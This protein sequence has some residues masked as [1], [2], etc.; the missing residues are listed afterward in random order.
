[1][2]ENDT[3][4]TVNSFTSPEMK[5]YD[6]AKG[7]DYRSSERY[8]T[9]MNTLLSMDG[10]LIDKTQALLKGKTGF[11]CQYEEP[12]FETVWSSIFDLDTLTIHRAE[13]DPRRKRFI[14]DER[15]PSI[16]NRRK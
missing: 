4:C 13:G 10:D 9:V 14:V 5:P 15:L 6:F 16:I 2:P 8:E 3:V 7:N 11:M 12:D 1:M